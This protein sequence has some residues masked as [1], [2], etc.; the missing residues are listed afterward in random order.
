M[1]ALRA[2]MPPFIVGWNWGA[3]LRQVNRDLHT[4]VVHTDYPF[5]WWSLKNSNPQMAIEAWPEG[6]RLI[7]APLW[8]V[9]SD[10]IDARWPWWQKL[11]ASDKQKLRPDLAKGNGSSLGEGMG[12]RFH[13]EL[14]VTDTV[15][16]VP[17]DN[18]TQGAIWGF[19]SRDTSVTRVEETGNNAHRLKLMSNGRPNWQR[20]LWNSWPQD[21][22]GSWPKNEHLQ[23]MDPFNGKRL[24]VSINMRRDSD[25]D[26][27]RSNEPLLRIRVHYVSCDTA[28][29]EQY[30]RFDSLPSSSAGFAP[31]PKTLDGSARGVVLGMRASDITSTTSQEIIVTR[32]MLPLGNAEEGSRDVTIMAHAVVDPHFRTSGG[33]PPLRSRWRAREPITDLERRAG[34]I[35]RM[36]IEVEYYDAADLA[37]DWIQIG[38]ENMTWLTQGYYDRIFELGYSDMLAN[39]VAYN[40]D[41]YATDTASWIKL[42]RWYNR[43]ESPEAWWES[44]RYLHQLLDSNS[45][46]EYGLHHNQERLAHITGMTELWEGD[47]TKITASVTAPYFDHG[48]M[49]RPQEFMPTLGHRS[50]VQDVYGSPR[51]KVDYDTDGP[52][53]LQS[54]MDNLRN[55]LR[56]RSWYLFSGLPWFSNIW[57]SGDYVV[58]DD[59]QMVRLAYH[60]PR[61]QTGEEV[62]MLIWQQIILGAK[63]VTYWYGAN[64][65]SMTTVEH[66]RR[67]QITAFGVSYG[68]VHRTFYEHLT[69]RDGKISTETVQ[70]NNRTADE[71]TRQLHSYRARD[72]R[73]GPDWLDSNNSTGLFQL[74][75]YDNKLPLTKILNDMIEDE[76]NHDQMYIGWQSNRSAMEEVVSDVMAMDT[77]VSRLQLKSWMMFTNQKWIEGNEVLFHELVDVFGLRSRHPNDTLASA[78]ESLDSMYFEFSVLEIDGVPLDS[79]F[80][81][82]VLNR[83]CSPHYRQEDGSV[84]LRNF[85]T[86]EQ[87]RQVRDGAIDEEGEIYRQAGS[88]RVEI[89]FRFDVQTESSRANVAEGRKLELNLLPGQ[90]ALILI[91]RSTRN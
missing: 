73:A 28:I 46:F 25:S 17:R 40:T 79:A 58:Q 30:L 27:K 33:N 65:D 75:E 13:A 15:G 62:S 77:L 82:G 63:G 51:K 21:L 55:K 20:V 19:R 4:N 10:S 49:G 85:V 89:P 61:H 83:R 53:G 80:V 7:M 11:Y 60:T 9:P 64:V 29:G 14:E 12:M 45:V 32:G 6:T 23:Q 91:T 50:G 42:W 84:D 39:L 3:A 22:F 70:R 78:W 69:A 71:R 56:H 52:F 35:D 36:W 59:G 66:Y 88:R 72:V 5:A 57:I 87:H 2:G 41:R 1:D 67:K 26:T 81:I 16:F 37:I 74:L 76:T 47:A 43:D 54:F 86:Y 18:D 8:F 48:H 44:N 90:G 68:P 31:L 34:Y 24:Y 38:T